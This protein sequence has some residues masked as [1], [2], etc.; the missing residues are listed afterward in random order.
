MYG[1]REPRPRQVRA[2]S[3]RLPHGVPKALALILFRD[4]HGCLSMSDLPVKHVTRIAGGEEPAPNCALLRRCW[5]RLGLAALFRKVRQTHLQR[6]PGQ[7]IEPVHAVHGSGSPCVR[8]AV[9]GLIA[10]PRLLPLRSPVSLHNTRHQLLGS[11]LLE[12]LLALLREMAITWRIR[13]AA[14]LGRAIQTQ[15]AK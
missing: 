10:I 1:W 5:L 4:D 7:I 3:A 9:E 12:V 15:P 14:F 8:T 13:I 2:T 11:E 6:I